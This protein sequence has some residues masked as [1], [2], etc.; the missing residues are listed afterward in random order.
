MSDAGFG[1]QVARGSFLSLLDPAECDALR[2][3][4]IPRTFPRGSVLMFE[5]EPGE[6]VMILVEGRV[7]VSRLGEEG[8]ETL[9]SIRDPGEVLGELA[10]VDGQPRLATVTALEPVQALVISSQTFRHHLE[11]TP[12]VAVALLE[13]ETR[14]FRETTLKRLQFATSDTVARLCGRL[15]ELAERYGEFADGSVAIV[16]PLSREELAAWTGGSRAAVWN[17]L[18]TLRELGWVE[19][20]RQRIIIGDLDALRARAA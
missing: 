2:E 18:Q 12:R 4:A 1:P 11:T 16:S 20:Q 19:T 13:V 6:R 9:L 17:A 10:F 5:Q 3:L 8:R 15:V 7:K 14:R